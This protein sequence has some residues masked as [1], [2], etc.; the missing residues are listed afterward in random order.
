MHLTKITLGGL[1]CLFLGACDKPA[2]KSAQKEDTTAKVVEKKEEPK[3]KE[4]EATYVNCTVY[5]AN[6]QFFFKSAKGDTITVSVLAPEA[7]MPGDSLTYAK[8]PD[9]MIDDDPKLEGVP[10]AHPKMLGKKFKII[11]NTKDEVTEVKL[12]E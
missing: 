6:T 12:S 1:L 7:R 3:T 4:I 10:G 5:A 11:Y 8:M 9:K 2:N